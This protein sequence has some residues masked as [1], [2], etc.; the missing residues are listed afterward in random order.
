M[1]RIFFFTITIKIEKNI[2]SIVKANA[3]VSGKITLE[4]IQKNGKT[5]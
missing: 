1:I 2:A 5:A 4:K 3:V